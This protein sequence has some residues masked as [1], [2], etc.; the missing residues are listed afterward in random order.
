MTARSNAAGILAMAGAAFLWS[1]AGLFIK[2]I[3][4]NPFAI[5]GLR[6][7]IA[8]LVILIYLR[9]P[10]L[11]WSFAQVGA[12]IANT[13][14]MLLFVSANKTTTA[15]NAILLQYVGP[16]FTA[17]I[18]AYI[19]KERARIEHWLGFLFVAVG[20]MVMFMD[21]LGGGLLLGNILAVMSGLTFSF[22]FVF[23]R[24]QKNASPLES[25]LLAHWFTA[26]IGLGVALFLPHP[27][28][29]WQV[30]GAIAMLGI[31]QVGVSAI[32][33]T[34]AIKRIPAVFANLIAVIEPV[35]NPVWVFLALG[36][37][38]GLQA[39]IG[40]IVIIIAVTVVSVISARRLES[41]K[42]G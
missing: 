11:H 23:M 7:L 35:F 12:A 10:K 40:G 20:M 3:D 25:I 38:P 24:M 29:T 17:I 42:T 39:I 21:K 31:F 36:E 33:F 41:R 30:A 19:L 26:A 13:A 28:F 34:V 18:G 22:F 8:S 14:T 1:I 15:A 16:I 5:A 37:A 2:V 27:V 4:W 6:S 32:L 9:R